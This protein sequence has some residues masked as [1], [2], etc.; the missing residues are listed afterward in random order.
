MGPGGK[1]PGERP[2]SGTV[3][4]TATGQQPVTVKVG[5]SGTFSVTLPPGRYRASGTS[6]EITEVDGG[7]TRELLRSRPARAAVC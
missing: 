1:Q 5:S 7:K 3:T 2:M 4:L 6:P